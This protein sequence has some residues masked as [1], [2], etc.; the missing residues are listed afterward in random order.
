MAERIVRAYAA[1][2][3]ALHVVDSG[4]VG[5]QAVLLISG[6]SQ[7]H[8][9]WEPQVEPFVAAGYRVIAFDNRGT[10][11]SDDLEAGDATYDESPTTGTFAEHA[12]AVLDAC[13]VDRAHVVGH[14]MGGRIAQ[15]LGASHGRRVSSLVLSATSPGESRGV[16]RSEDADRKLL[17]ADPVELALLNWSSAWMG[18]HMDLVY[19]LNASIT[20]RARQRALHYQA[21]H[22]HDCWRSLSRISAPTLVMHGTDDQINPVENASLLV[23]QIPE[24]RLHLVPGGRHGYEAEFAEVFNATVVE[25]WEDL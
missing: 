19:R 22:N 8:T 4:Q 18:R 10:G 7:D 2:G 15:W 24:A 3:G 14:S 5:D 9:F 12:V 25:F 1:D 23:E 13:H 11:L 17:S 21:S 6:M 16:R 20:P